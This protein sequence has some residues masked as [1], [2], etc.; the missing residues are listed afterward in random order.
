MP[1]AGGLIFST[2]PD[3]L[4]FSRS[5]LDR[6]DAFMAGLVE[7]G[8]VAGAA[9]LLMRHGEV[10]AFRTFG[11]ARLGEAQ[12]LARDALFRI[13]SMTKPV[14]AVAMMILFEEGLWALDDPITTVLPEFMTTEVYCGVDENGALLTEKARRAPTL[15]ELMSHTAGLGYGLFDVHPVE[16]AYRDASVLGA[17]SLDELARRAARIPLMFQPG[18]EWFYSIAADLQGLVVERLSGQTF[19][20]FL[21]DRIFVPLG[22]VD[23]GFQ[24]RPDN[25]ARL[26]TIYSDDGAGGLQEATHVFDLAINDYTRAPRYQGGGGGLLSTATDYGRFCQ[27]ILNGGSLDGVRILA[28]DTVALMSANAVSPAVLAVPNALRLLPFSPALGFGLG[29]SVVL[30]PAALGAPEGRGTLSWGG[31][32]GTWFWIDPENDLIFVGLTQRMAD[33][34]SAAFRSRARA[35]VYEALIHPEK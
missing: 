15:R 7:E 34:V 6:L 10:A 21:R 31:G 19:G 14:A 30:D 2:G 35:L 17:A 22:M 8:Q 18:E 33:P 29:F 32:G 12:P 11:H 3:D 5:G 28:P 25:E 26:A 27:M 16:R 20:D 13:Y 23:T 1:D 4:G 9:A 24:T